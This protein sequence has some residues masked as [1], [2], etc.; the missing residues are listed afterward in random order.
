MRKHIPNL[1][2]IA[3]GLLLVAYAVRAQLNVPRT[4]SVQRAL[5]YGA[6]YVALLG[7]TVRTL[8]NRRENVCAT[9]FGFKLVTVG[10]LFLIVLSTMLLELLF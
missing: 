6:A 5:R 8:L 7:M 9:N 10:L 2:W 1:L 4:E 3:A